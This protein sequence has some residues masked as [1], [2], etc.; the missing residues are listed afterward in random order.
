MAVNINIEGQELKPCP[1]CGLTPRIGYACGEHFIVGQVKDCPVCGDFSEMHTDEREEIKAWNRTAEAAENKQKLLPCP[2][3]GGKAETDYAFYDYND[4]G[5]HCVECGAY[6]CTVKDDPQE[7]IKAWNR[8][9]YY[10]TE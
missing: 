1:C 5:V 8:R 9:A 6:V 2:F 3:C 10:G 7:A 4:Y